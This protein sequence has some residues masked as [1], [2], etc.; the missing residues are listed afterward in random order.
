MQVIQ[1]D[2]HLIKFRPSPNFKKMK[3]FI[4]SKIDH[5]E[6]TYRATPSAAPDPPPPPNISRAQKVKPEVQPP[7]PL[8][9]PPVDTPLNLNIQI[10]QEIEDLDYHM[11]DKS[12]EIE[13]ETSQG[14]KNTQEKSKMPICRD[15]IRGTCKRQGT[16]K[17]VHKYDVS[18]LVGVYT[19][20]H[21][22]QNSV[23]T[24]ANCKYVHASVFEERN[25]YRTGIL[26][27]HVLAHHRKVNVLQP[28][29]PPPPPEEPPT[30]VATVTFSNPPPPIPNDCLSVNSIENRSFS[31]LLP[32]RST[33]PL[34]RTW[35]TIEEFGSSC[36][37]DANKQTT[38]NCKHCDLMEFRLQYNK[39]KVEEM[40][41][42]KQ[43][44]DKKM[45]LL[46]KKSDK[47]YSIIL[48]LLKLNVLVQT[49]E[50][51]EQLDFDER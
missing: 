19:F 27:P 28:P 30:D 13:A 33:S 42:S 36:E 3:K 41:H 37:I 24:Y 10:K 31:D 25:F 6:I 34:K 48:A 38:K 23:C 2:E 46:D 35:K 15:F 8:D 40:L 16:C 1:T 50:S 47:L 26:P 17:F 22:Y 11:C 9:P 21:K 51:R 32:L 45:A 20:C 5:S 29:P 44:L 4:K 43:E 7:L 14:S 18:Q 12:P 49:S 39:D